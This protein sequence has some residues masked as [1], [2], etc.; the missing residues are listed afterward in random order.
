MC[1]TNFGGRTVPIKP[2]GKDNKNI[3]PWVAKD[4]NKLEMLEITYNTL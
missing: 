3:Y 2:F 1:K 4:L